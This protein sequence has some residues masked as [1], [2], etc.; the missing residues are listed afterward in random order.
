[1]RNHSSEAPYIT[2][3]SAAKYLSYAFWRAWFL[4]MYFRRFG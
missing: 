2:S 1:M 4:V 3:W